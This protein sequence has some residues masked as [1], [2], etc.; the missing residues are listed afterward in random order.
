MRKFL[1]ASCAAAFLAACQTTDGGT[2]A[3]SQANKP[4]VVTS[5]NMAAAKAASKAIF[6]R[7]TLGF[8]VARETDSKVLFNK[9]LPANVNDNNPLKDR[10]KGAPVSFVELTFQAEGGK[11]RVT[12]DNWLVLNPKEANKDVFNLLATPDGARLQSKLNE[13]R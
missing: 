9:T 10:T 2:T 6:T 4:T 8:K 5:K 1:I 11:T 12:G 13:L 7:P 3:F